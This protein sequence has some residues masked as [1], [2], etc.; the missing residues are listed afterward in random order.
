MARKFLTIVGVL[1]VVG[2]VSVIVEAVIDT[3]K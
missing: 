3:F 1:A 2:L